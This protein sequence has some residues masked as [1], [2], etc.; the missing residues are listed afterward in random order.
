MTTSLVVG[1][2][3]GSGI[4]LLPASLGA[5]GGISIFGWLFTAVGATLLAFTFAHLGRIIPKAGGPYAYTRHGFGDFAGFL[6]AWGYWISAWAGNAAIAT[7]LVG[8][9]AVFWPALQQN[10][11]LAAVVA[12]ANV[13]LLTAVNARGV[14]TAGGVQL[15]TTVLK[16]IPLVIIGTVGLLFFQPEHFTPLNQSGGSSWSA[17]T[18]TAALTLWAFLGLES[19]TVPADQ[20]DRPARTIPLATVVGTIATAAI[21]LASTV[22]VMGVIPSAVLSTS[23]AP[24]AD[25][26]SS[27]FGGWARYLVA[28]GASIAC[29]GALNGWILIQGQVPR[30][31]ALDG[32]FP[33]RF[34]RLSQR[35]TPVFGLVVSSTLITILIAMNYTS[36]LV[37]QFTF[38]IL[39]ATLA[40]L[41]PYAFCT[42]AAL[43]TGRA[44]V[45]VSIVAVLGFLYSIWAI[46]GAGRDAVYWGVFLFVVGVPVYVG[47]K[48]GERRRE[49][50]VEKRETWR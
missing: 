19:G 17:V 32:L 26:A 46:G 18:A 13:W 9:L 24:Y 28:A 31:A 45:A 6:V 22:A 43:L 36:S 4:F 20:I 11:T 2:M 48:W 1:N 15:V 16:L 41:V 23:T 8:Y 50:G 27:M 29:F 42:M 44:T 49:L 10:S 14:R 39:L 3:I 30:A 5:Y 40:A 34:G 47:M 38:I 12:V 25:A 35:G 33:A 21:Y 7:A 37:E